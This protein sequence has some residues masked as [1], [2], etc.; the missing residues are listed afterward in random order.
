MDE[1]WEKIAEKH[2]LPSDYR[3]LMK[4]DPEKRKIFFDEY[5]VQ[6][7]KLR[8]TLPPVDVK[9]VVDHID[10]VVKITGKADYVGLGSDF[11]GIGR[12]PEGLEHTGKIASITKE[13]FARG[14]KETDIRKI[15]GGNFLRVLRKVTSR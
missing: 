6:E 4:A 3:E 8:K 15:L 14:Y 13:L 10:H 12:P 11:D 1:L 7:E 9:T 2:G 5:R